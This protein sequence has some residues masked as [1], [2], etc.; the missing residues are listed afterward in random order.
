MRLAG[1]ALLV[2]T[3]S[4]RDVVGPKHQIAELQ[5]ARQKWRAQNLHTYAFTLQR[6]CECL[7]VDRLY[8]LVE[9]DTVAGAFDLDTA[10]WVN[11]QFGRTVEDLF[12][13]IQSAID[14][15]ADVIRVEYD[16][17]KGFPRS[18]E[19]DGALQVVDDEITYWASDVHTI[20]PPP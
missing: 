7:N 1:L 18:I 15:R 19:Y 17:A 5:S 6:N 16:V 4:C 20:P 13:F 9:S 12:T 14:Q 8:V 11:H 3:I 2:L 10:E